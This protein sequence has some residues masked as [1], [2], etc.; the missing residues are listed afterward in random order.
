MKSEDNV[1]FC[2]HF[3]PAFLLLAFH[4]CLLFH[5][6]HRFLFLCGSLTL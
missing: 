6:D 4:V 2:D 5:K 1:N 3:F